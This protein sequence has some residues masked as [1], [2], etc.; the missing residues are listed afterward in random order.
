[1][2]HSLKYNFVLNATNT[3]VGLLFPLI[4][5]PYVSR[6]IEPDGIGLVQYFQSIVNYL[7]LLCTL[8]IPIYAVREIARY[9]HDTVTRNKLAVEILLLHLLLSAAGYIMAGI[10]IFCVDSISSH[11]KIFLILSISIFL[12]VIGATWF[13]QAI[14]DFTYITVRSLLVRI[15]SAILLFTFVKT[16]EDI[17]PYAVI[18]VIADAGNNIFNAIRLR[19]FLKGRT[20]S[21]RELRLRQHIAPALKVFV[22]NLITSIYIN[23]DSV[24]LGSISSDAA[25]GYYA[26][27]TRITRA[28]LGIVTALGITL[29]PRLSDFIAQGNM[30]EFR[31]TER[32]ALD[33]I[34]MLT[35]PMTVGL[36]LV[37]PQLI[38]VFSGTAFA[39]AIPTLQIIAPTLLLIGISTVVGMQ[40]LYSQGKEHL[41]IISTAAGAIVNIILNL[42]LIPVLAQDGAAYATV[43]AEFTVTAVM[44]VIGRKYIAYRFIRNRNVLMTVLFTA[45]SSGCAFYV[46]S[47][48]HV[49]VFAQLF[50]QIGTA[51]GV[52]LVCLIVSRNELILSLTLS[53]QQR[54]KS[55]SSK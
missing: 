15:F 18:I 25:V 30:A 33:F 19:K 5:F 52:Y 31:A 50:I 12:N 43:V 17:I 13:F 20:F 23:L 47:A 27:A 8:G 26:A 37:A 22:L 46:S 28:S 1:M 39:P 9:Q 53:L 38:P 7:S 34:L 14:E 48:L 55:L 44:I 32:K 11:L 24:M 54:L 2:K 10:L 51:M 36:I 42:W 6:I 29:L 3:V 4:T 16:K 35:M 49:S 40:I 41:V 21:L 45:I